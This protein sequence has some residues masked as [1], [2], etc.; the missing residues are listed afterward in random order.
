MFSKRD[1]VFGCRC[2]PCTSKRRFDRRQS[3]YRIAERSELT[4][5]SAAGSCFSSEPFN[6]AN[7]VQSIPHGCTDETVT[8]CIDGTKPR[9]DLGAINERSE[10]PLPKQPRAHRRKSAV[11]DSEKCP[12]SLRAPHRLDQLEVPPRHLVERQNASRAL[13]FRSGEV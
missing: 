8:E 1:V 13:D 11:E 2:C 4:G 12:G 5:R 10:Y 3:S 9:V 7:A 6:I